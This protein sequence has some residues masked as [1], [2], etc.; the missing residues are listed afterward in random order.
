MEQPPSIQE[1]DA[2]VSAQAGSLQ[3]LIAQHLAGQSPVSNQLQPVNHTKEPSVSLSDSS[4]G[5]QD[6]WGAVAQNQYQA[7]NHPR[8]LGQRLNA[9]DT[10]WQAG[11]EHLLPTPLFRLRVTKERLV[12]ERHEAE[13]A[14]QEARQL[15]VL[16]KK[17]LVSLG[18]QGG[19]FK[20]STHQ[21]VL[22][23]LQERV[24][25]LKR[26]EAHVDYQL[27]Q[28]MYQQA[29]PLQKLL[30]GWVSLGLG[31]QKFMHQALQ[32]IGQYSPELWL[33]RLDPQQ[34]ALA[35]TN[36]QLQQVAHWLL[37]QQSVTDPANVSLARY[38]TL[39]EQLSQVADA[40][41]QALRQRPSLWRRWM[42]TLLA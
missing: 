42:K 19:S 23:A 11:I 1:I 40:Q 6:L 21:R 13:T 25:V 24:L 36:T 26:H 5:F 9:T 7:V 10:T 34:S 39:Y 29:T 22:Q 4:V 38:L 20:T 18:S 12:R 28:L 15:E 8:L 3:S 27:Q 41:Q 32:G 16:G 35:L 31:F 2:G 30:W 14:L 17:A 37:H 33:R